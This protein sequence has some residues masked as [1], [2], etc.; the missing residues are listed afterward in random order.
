MPAT[1]E[2]SRT[3]GSGTGLG[4][5]W[6]V[7]DLN[8]NHSTF[9]GV[10]AALTRYLPG[11]DFD[12]GLAMANKIHNQGQAIVWSGMREHAELYWEQLKGAGLTM[13]PL[14]QQLRTTRRRAFRPARSPRASSQPATPG[15]C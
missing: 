11:Y 5:A 3:G 6:K 13:A 4:G 14:E 10:A 15:S 1:I 2:K 8:D 9:E 7:I 12:K